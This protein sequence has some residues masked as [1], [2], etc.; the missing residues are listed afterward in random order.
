MA[1]VGHLAAYLVGASGEEMAFHQGKALTVGFH[2][3]FCDRRFGAL[4]RMVH[5]VDPVLSGI[6]EKLVLQAPFG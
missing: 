1:G 3:V 2:F 6:L 4:H 5:H